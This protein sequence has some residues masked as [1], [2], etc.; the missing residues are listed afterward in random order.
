MGLDL[1]GLMCGAKK[2]WQI[3]TAETFCWTSIILS[4]NFMFVSQHSQENNNEFLRLS[5]F[6]A[7]SSSVC[8]PT[9]YPLGM[10]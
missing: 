9:N 7:D 6:T 2:A 1:G 3:D 5:H 8:I 4:L 10:H